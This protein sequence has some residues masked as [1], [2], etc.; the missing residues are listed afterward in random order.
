MLKMVFR[1]RWRRGSFWPRAACATHSHA[2]R[3]RGSA[4]VTA[5]SIERASAFR[6]CTRASLPRSTCTSR[7]GL[8]TPAWSSNDAAWW[9]SAWLSGRDA[10][11]IACARVVS[12][13]CLIPRANHAHETSATTIAVRRTGFIAR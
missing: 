5:E 11:R 3:L 7:S 12:C 4:C 9:A 8:R 2:S 6:P 13:A 10:D 1:A